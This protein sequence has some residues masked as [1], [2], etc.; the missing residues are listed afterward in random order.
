MFLKIYMMLYF[1]VKRLFICLCPVQWRQKNQEKL[2]IDASRFV[3]ES[4]NASMI[5]LYPLHVK[6]AQEAL[7]RAQT[8]RQDRSLSE[9]EKILIYQKLLEAC[10]SLQNVAKIAR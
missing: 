3:I 2:I 9:Y 10:V 7:Q 5:K 1:K 6:R 8:V 4:L